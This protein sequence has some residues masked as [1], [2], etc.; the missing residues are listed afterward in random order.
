MYAVFVIHR[1]GDCGVYNCASRQGFLDVLGLPEDY[2]DPVRA[3]SPLRFSV[4]N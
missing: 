1:T 2:R 4:G 3:G